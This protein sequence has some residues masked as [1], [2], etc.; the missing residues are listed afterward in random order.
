MF[1]DSVS[2][3]ISMLILMSITYRDHLA[4]SIMGLM[5][6]DDFVLV[7]DMLFGQIY[8]L[9]TDKY[10]YL[11]ITGMLHV[12]AASGFNIG[13]I[14]TLINIFTNRFGRYKS[15]FI[16]WFFITLY[17]VMTDLSISIIRA[18]L[19]MF[20]RKSGHILAN[21]GY[22][23]LILL[24]T[25]S[26]MILLYDR[27][28]LENISFQLSIAASLGIM[29]FMPIF[30]SADAVVE[31]AENSSLKSLISESFQTTLAAQ[32][33]TTPII[34]FHFAELSL[35]SIIVNVTLAWITP[36]LTLGGLLLYCVSFLNTF[37]S[38]VPILRMITLYV[39]MMSKLFIWSVSLFGRLEFLFL[40]DLQVSQGIIVL[41]LVVLGIVYYKLLKRHEK[42]RTK[43]STPYFIQSDLGFLDHS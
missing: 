3:W 43:N 4:K 39:G 27:A 35:L 19:M 26:L 36:I 22:H 24:A 28:F 20:L 9:G 34:I 42:K 31:T 25:A 7:S 21:K 11:K 29:L 30:S 41:Y 8:Q 33:L 12:V 37:V 32:L 17:L 40:K 1:I 5:N 14:T 10:H 38:F 23:N 16:W 6:A 13:L 2:N 15:F 18:Y